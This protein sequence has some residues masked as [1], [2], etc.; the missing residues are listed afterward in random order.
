MTKFLLFLCPFIFV[1]ALPLHGMAA[2]SVAVK[3][4]D[5]FKTLDLR[6]AMNGSCYDDG[7]ADNQAGGWT[8]EGGN[9]FHVWPELE[10]GAMLHRGY[11]F[12]FVDPA[13]NGG[14]N[15]LVTGAENCWPDLPRNHELSFEPVTSRFIFILHSEG[16]I[17]GKPEIGG[18]ITVTYAD[19]TSAILPLHLGK[20]INDWWQGS[21]WGNYEE[22]LPDA[23]AALRDS[24]FNKKKYEE[25]GGNNFEADVLK[26]TRAIRWPVIR[27]LNSFSANW[28]IPVVF[29]G[30]RWENPHP[31]KPM[32]SIRLEST[33]DMLIAMA[34]V[35]FSD[36]DF[37]LNRQILGALA[38]P[39][40]PPLEFFDRIKARYRDAL[41][42]GWLKLPWTKGLKTIQIRSDKI[43]TVR[44]DQLADFLKLYDPACYAVTSQTDPNFKEPV[45]PVKITR[46]SR[47]SHY[48]EPEV[49]VDHYMHVEMPVAFKPGNRYM[50]QVANNLLPETAKVVNRA[51][52]S[53]EETPNPSFK[54]NQVGYTSAAGVKLAYLS[55][56]LGEGEPV[57]LSRFTQFEI[58]DAQQGKVVFTGTI[59]PHVESDLQGLDKLYI[60]DLS[61]FRDEGTFHLWVDGLGRSYDFLNGRAAA[62]RMYVVSH[63]GLLFQRSGFEIRDP[64]EGKWTRPLAHDKIYVTK[65]NITHP[66]MSMGPVDP[67]DPDSPYYV[68]QGPLEIRG[69]HY[70]A[71]DFDL[72]PMHINIPE[73]LMS[74]YE[75]L[76]E[77]FTDGQ[78]NIPEKGNGIPDI[79]DE[80][81]WNLLS[82]EYIQDYATKIRGLDG[83]VAPGMETYIHPGFK[84]GMG[85]D[86]YPYFMR[87]VTPYFSFG[88]AAA[89]A[90]AARVFKPYDAARADRYLKRALRAYAYAVSHTNEPQPTFTVGGQKPD[91]G[92]GWDVRQLDSAR[93][94]ASGQLFATTGEQVYFD[95]FKR[96]SKNTAGIFSGAISRWGVLWGFLGT[97]KCAEDPELCDHLRNI[98]IAEA[99]TGV[100][101]V[102]EN[103]KSGYRASSPKGGGWGNT[104]CVVKNIE[105]TTRAYL[106]TREQKYLDAVA[107]S[108][109]FTLG[110]NPSEM[111]WMTGAG[112]DHPM[113]PLNANSITDHVE[114][115]TPGILI[116]GPSNYYKDNKSVLYPDKEAMGFYRRVVDVHGFSAGC[117]YSVWETQ[118]PFLFAVGTLLPDRNPAGIR[119]TGP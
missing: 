43:I 103:G 118:A 15:L 41:L 60:M 119:A 77:K 68:P 9:D 59:K 45:H 114:E 39:A 82:L 80:A 105:A 95:E 50:L 65:A 67:D 57:D 88:A 6:A 23:P 30:L 86:P 3:D 40:P 92:E 81:A 44:L 24:G 85:K 58:R 25:A 13:S 70:D 28:N 27:G 91:Q 110:M 37:S 100:Q 8:D 113:D 62:E 38:P 26:Y 61:G 76:P 52:F 4:K 98:L 73:Y 64:Y 55:S 14:K 19:G 102:E 93:C 84:Q 115:P 96:L 1:L 7:V 116:Y 106:L 32:V 36:Q 69:G 97:D 29:W 10:F 112:T 22:L 72:R 94:W 20:E 54:V 35:T 79:L 5:G 75:A 66:S 99:D 53:M 46:F 104:S 117:E 49:F 107:T 18:T 108:V 16:R 83:G 48:E 21:W 56:Y 109:D 51:E 31:E 63:A 33:G 71:G 11:Y 17:K 12:D 90:Q 89:F 101:I 74:L 111:S 47:A 2:L 87:K 78:V 42:P 34:A